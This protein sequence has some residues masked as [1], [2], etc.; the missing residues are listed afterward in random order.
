MELEFSNKELIKGSVTIYCQ[1]E[2]SYYV[3]V[4]C[5]VCNKDVFA[6][7]LCVGTERCAKE[8]VK[9]YIPNYCP[10]CGTKLKEAEVNLEK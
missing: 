1:A 9:K 2:T 4:K 8:V 6:H 10:H 7:T 3:K 5:A